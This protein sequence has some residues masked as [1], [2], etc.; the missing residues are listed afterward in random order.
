MKAVIQRVTGSSVSVEGFKT[1]A[2]GKGFTILLGVVK[3][4]SEKE[5]EI[6]AEKTAKLRVFCDDNGKMNLALPDVNGSVLVISQFTLCA[7]TR[8]GNRPS[9]INSAEPSLAE[10]LY[11]HFIKKLIENGITDVQKGIFGAKMK[12][13]I[14]N[15]GPVTI[16]LDSD[17]WMKAGNNSL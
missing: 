10:K 13:E 11:E 9:F 3:G 4:D 8:K 12:V 5:A 1:G 2:I 6:L 7:D 15:D 14:Y 17:T 16:I